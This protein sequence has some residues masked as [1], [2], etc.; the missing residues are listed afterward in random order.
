MK[1]FL[2]ALVLGF[3]GAFYFL[4][5]PVSYGKKLTGYVIAIFDH[6]NGDIVI[7]LNNDHH[8]FL[9]AGGLQIG[10]DLKKL[11]SK[12][13]GKSVDIWYTHPQWPLNTTPFITRLITEENIVYSKW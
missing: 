1:K 11:Q 6:D 5:L 4:R 9:I 3:A 7:K 10:I 13:I 2:F 12:L 8:D